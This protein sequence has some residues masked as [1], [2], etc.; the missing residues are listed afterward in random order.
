MPWTARLH[1]DFMPEA[2]ALPEAVQDELA[3]LMLLLADQGRI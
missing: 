3:A 1:P 2:K